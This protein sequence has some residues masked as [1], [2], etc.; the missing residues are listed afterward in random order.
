[1]SSTTKEVEKEWGDKVV[2][3]YLNMAD[4]NDRALGEKLNNTSVTT[5]QIIGKDG[6]LVKQL[7]GLQNKNVIEKEIEQLFE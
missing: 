5:L 2:F 4:K 7:S 6:K 3:I 1:M